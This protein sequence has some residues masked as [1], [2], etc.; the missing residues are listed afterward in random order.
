[1]Q[2]LMFYTRATGDRFIYILFAIP[3]AGRSNAPPKGFASIHSCHKWLGTQ[4]RR[5]CPNRKAPLASLAPRRTM[6]SLATP[7]GRWPKTGWWSPHRQL[8]CRNCCRQRSSS[9]S[10]CRR[11]LDSRNQGYCPSRRTHRGGLDSRQTT[12]NPGSRDC[13]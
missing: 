8:H 3:Q 7:R 13:C 5:C 6:C 11:F 1:M 12:S 2:H 10:S 4:S 9:T